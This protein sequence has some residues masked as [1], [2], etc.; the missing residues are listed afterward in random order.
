MSEIRVVVA[1]DFGT[2]YSG[3]AYAHRSN[4]NEIS[5]YCN[6]QDYNARFKTFTV[7]KYDESLKLISW[8]YPALAE[9]P[10]RRKNLPI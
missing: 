1:I 4:P 9:K 7:L 3:F 5:A 8:G 10:N 6:W 2:T